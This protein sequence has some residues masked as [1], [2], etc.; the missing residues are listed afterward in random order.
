MFFIHGEKHEV[1]GDVYFIILLRHQH[2]VTLTLYSC[3]KNIQ[4]YN[5]L[6]IHIY[7]LVYVRSNM[8]LL[9]YIFVWYMLLLTQEFCIMIHYTAAENK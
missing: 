1:H 5:I 3:G 2:V 6:Y 4:V 9:I 7:V 8:L